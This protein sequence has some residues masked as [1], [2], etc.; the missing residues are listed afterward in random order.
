M[1]GLLFTLAALAGEAESIATALTEITGDYLKTREQFGVP[2][3]SFQALQHLYADMVL[4]EEE[5]RSLAW[6]AAHAIHLEDPDTRQRNLRAAKSRVGN[7][8]RPWRKQRCSCTAALALAT[9]TSL[10]ITCAA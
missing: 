2:I 10:D 7:W 3:A 1:D 6:L 5:I 9:S 8:A 4:A